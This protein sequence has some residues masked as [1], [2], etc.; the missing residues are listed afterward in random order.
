MYRIDSLHPDRLVCNSGLHSNQQCY[1]AECR[2]KQQNKSLTSIRFLT[3]V[4][5]GESNART[6]RGPFRGVPHV[7][8]RLPTPC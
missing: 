7:G 1:T 6:T 3:T 4:S 8:D 5:S 2:V